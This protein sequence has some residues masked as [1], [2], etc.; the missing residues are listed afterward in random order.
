MDLHSEEVK[1]AV[2]LVYLYL[3]DGAV[4]GAAVAQ[5]ILA[6]VPGAASPDL[7]A[8]L[9]AIAGEPDSSTDPLIGGAYRDAGAALRAAL[10]VIMS[11]LIEEAYASHW[12]P[13]SMI[14][15]LAVI[16]S[17]EKFGMITV[18]A[19]VAEL[20]QSM[21]QEAGGWWLDYDA[22]GEPLF[23]SMDEVSL[24]LGAPPSPR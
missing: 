3:P 11:S 24:F 21:A 7:N 1:R 8:R 9:V 18:D 19:E 20:L 12:G 10:M 5:K 16:G 15:Q 2:E 13:P 23:L 17:G 14:R 22:A 6:G 4:D